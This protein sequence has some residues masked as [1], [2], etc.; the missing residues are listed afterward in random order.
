MTPNLFRWNQTRISYMHTY[1]FH[2]YLV[3][4]Y[5][6]FSVLLSDRSCFSVTQFLMW[7]WKRPSHDLSADLR[8][9]WFETLR[10][11][12]FLHQTGKICSLKESF[13]HSIMTVVLR[14]AALFFSF[15][16]F[17]SARIQTA[18]ST[19]EF[20]GHEIR[21]NFTVK[22]RKE[23]IGQSGSIWIQIH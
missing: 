17:Y 11:V 18:L 4:F 21:T 7:L 5:L 6:F 2:T 10:P 16:F 8:G 3:L 15:C 23:Q 14:K 13:S 22:P 12:F 20:D 9:V 1:R 19:S